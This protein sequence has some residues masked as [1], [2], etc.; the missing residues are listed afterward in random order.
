[1][2]ASP[3][4]RYWTSAGDSWNGTEVA[5]PRAG[6][7][8]SSSARCNSEWLRH[9]PHP[10][11]LQEVVSDRRLE[12][13]ESRRHP[14]DSRRLRCCGSRAAVRATRAVIG[15]LRP[16]ERRRAAI[17]QTF[18]TCIRNKLRSNSHGAEGDRTPDLTD[19]NGALSQLSYSPALRW[20]N[21]LARGLLPVA[22]GSQHKAPLKDPR[23]LSTQLS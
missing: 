2:D 1:M 10:M 22:F 16:T 11:S 4:A 19:A 15:T 14:M 7:H 13:P 20:L 17:L 3:R 6:L 5:T 12:K 9:P 8:S 23:G 21:P 18:Y